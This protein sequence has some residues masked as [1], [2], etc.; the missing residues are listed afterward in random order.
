M[1]ARLIKEYPVG[2]IFGQEE[3][4][5]IKRVLESGDPLT[6]GPD[7]E[8]FEKEFAEYCNAKYAVA[9]SSCGAAL[10]IS[11]QILKLNL[12]SCPILLKLCNKLRSSLQIF[13][14]F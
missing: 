8:L 2:T 11:S 13:H 5:A 6:R 14:Q 7:V 9:V 4:D 12:G 3:L 1:K 10:T